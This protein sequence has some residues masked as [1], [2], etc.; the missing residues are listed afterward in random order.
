MTITLYHYPRCSTCRRARAS[1]GERD[2]TLVDLATTPP[3][4]ETL[5][6][7]WQ[8][9]GL[10][11]RR[12]F[13]TS[14]RSYRGGGWKDRLPQTSEADQLAALASDGMLIKRPILDTGGAVLVGFK[15]EDWTRSLESAS[16]ESA[17]PA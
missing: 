10:P 7:L 15:A 1:L 8:R 2:V 5:R 6:S 13:N 4:A 11:L 16:P 9:S 14:G 17:P 12:F 3:S